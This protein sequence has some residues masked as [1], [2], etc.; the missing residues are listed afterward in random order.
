MIEE[1]HLDYGVSAADGWNTQQF[2]NAF[3]LVFIDTLPQYQYVTT[4]ISVKNQR[5]SGVL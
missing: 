2:R 4:V 3:P 1:H 5:G